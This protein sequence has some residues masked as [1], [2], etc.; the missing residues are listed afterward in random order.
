MMTILFAV[1][2]AFMGLVLDGGRIYFEKRR[3]QAAADAGAYGGAH[4]LKRGSTGLIETAGKYDAKLNGFEHGT[5]TIDVQVNHPPASGNHAG[6]TGYVEV[7]ITQTVP[8]YFR[9]VLIIN[10]ATVRARAVAGLENNGDACVVA[11]DREARP[12]LRVAG[13]PQLIA[14]CGIMANSNDDWGL[15]ANG[16]GEIQATWTGV[17]GGYHLAGGGTIT[18]PATEGALGMLDPLASIALENPGGVTP[19]YNLG[20]INSN[21]TLQPGRYVGGIKITGSGTVVNFAPGLYVLDSGMDVSGGTLRGTEVSFYNT[22]NQ[23]ISITGASDVE[24]SAP[25]S[26]PYQGMLF[27]GDP[28]APDKNPGHKFRGTSESS[29][30][31]AIH[32]PSQHVDWAGSN[33]S[34]GTWSMIVANTIDLTGNALVQQINGP[35]PGVLPPVTT[36]TLVE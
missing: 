34:V 29:F 20:N 36:V 4:E 32:F 31:G 33:D 23:L 21:T 25:T 22:G 1:L 11:L 7:V 19:V 27:W 6:S 3:M 18:P 16:G 14:N 9:R 17:S 15:Q 24:L 8:T 28:T 26:G 5:G 35:P 2:L 10:D 30:T 12:G 13:T